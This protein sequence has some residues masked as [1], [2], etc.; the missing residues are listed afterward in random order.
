[1]ILELD[2]ELAQRLAYEDYDHNDGYKVIKDE[3]VGT[4][5]WTVHH[6][7]VIQRIEDGRYFQGTYQVGATECQDEGPFEYT[8]AK[9]IEVVPEEQVITVFKPK[10]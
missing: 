5:R 3:I 10:Q 9:F 8:D 7:L 1:M 2:K 4:G 6:V